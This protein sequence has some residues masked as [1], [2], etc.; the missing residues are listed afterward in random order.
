MKRIIIILLSIVVVAYINAATIHSYASESVLS[1]GNFVKIRTAESGIYKISY[2]EI[3]QMGLKPENIRILGYGGA[4]LEQ[5]FSKR[6]IDDLPSVP[7]YMYKG[8]DGKFNKGDYILFYAQGPVSWSFTGLRFHHTQNTYSQYGHYFLSD[9]AG[10]QLLLDV[11]CKDNSSVEAFDV[12]TYQNYELHELDS[13]NLIDL[14]G[15]HGGGREWYG[16]K[17]TKGS[18]LSF[19][20]KALDRV[21][22]EPATLS[23]DVVAKSFNAASEFHVN[24]LDEDYTISVNKITDGLNSAMSGSLNTRIHSESTASPIVRIGFESADASAIGYL[25]Y[26]ELVTTCSLNLRNGLLLARNRDDYGSDRPSRF[27]VSGATS[28]TQVWNITKL[29]SI[30]SVETKLN[31]TELTFLSSNRQLQEYVII[32]PSTCP[33]KR[34]VEFSS[35]KI[36]EKVANQNLHSLADVEMLI[37]TNSEFS[38][39]AQKLAEAHSRIDGLKTQVVT[40]QQVYNEFSSGTTDATSFRWILKMLRDKVE[41]VNCMCSEPKY[42]LLIG[43]GTFDN[44]KLLRTSGNNWIVTYQAKNSINE[45]K[46]YSSDDYFTFLDDNEGSSDVNATMDLSVGRL[47]VNT[48]E[49]ADKLAD[50]IIRYISSKQPGSW[51]RQLVFLADDGDGNLHTES[52]DQGAEI[53]RK[54]N[55]DFVVNKIYL[56]AYKQLTNASG[57][58]YPIAKNQLDNFM[59]NGLLLFDYCG[60]AGFNNI[61]SELMLTAKE[62]REMSNQNQGF[63]MLA[64][65]NFAQFD[66]RVQSAA[67]EAVLNPNGGAI[68]VMASCRTVYATQNTRLNNYLME[69]LFEHDE[70][71][72]YPNTIGDAIRKA[73]NKYM[74]LHKDENKLPYLLLGDPAI[75]LHYPTDYQVIAKSTNDTL[76]ALSV[77]K[78]EGYIHSSDADTLKSFNGVVHVSVYDKAAQITT[79]DNDNDKKKVT[80]IDYKNMIFSGTTEVKDGLFEFTMMVPKDIQYNYGTGRMV[81]YAQDTITESEGVGYNEEFVVGGSSNQLTTDT[82]GPDMKIYLNNEA[83]KDGDMTD[84]QPHFYAHISDEN[85]INTIG[86]GIGHDLLL[87]IDNDIKQTY[88]LNDYFVSKKGSYSEG[89]ISY[90]LSELEEGE[91][92]LMF[93]AWD[94]LNNSS[95][96]S[97]TFVV[98]KNI[99]ATVYSVTAYPNPVSE[100]GVAYIRV[101][102]DHPDAVLELKLS[103][104][105]MA[106]NRKYYHE[107]IGADDVSINIPQAGLAAGLYIYNVEIKTA[108]TSYTRKA[109]KLII[110]K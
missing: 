28:T 79:L 27:H 71:L 61:T 22:S 91:H 36:F 38:S 69:S 57:E 83:F 85:G 12:Y 87:I 51:K 90:K 33:T 95:S 64:T 62:V 3:S 7:F 99:K 20:M 78:I 5:D 37:I 109:G 52:S 6:K 76:K 21:Y 2:D 65:C 77:N 44:R 40:D 101:E 63:W 75:R 103:V 15:A 92:E 31:G 1:S 43:D 35:G 17:F 60:H 54:N 19:P 86:N 82:L 30:Y 72:Y 10:E 70:N 58:S 102:H 80:Y 89:N 18:V 97:L 67:E 84:I 14:S 98:K 47:T 73:K 59:Q 104:Y 105:D 107:Q 32:D 55:P 66:A 106:G 16:E 49:E 56:D 11:I 46:A 29:D 110:V 4:M 100:S 34:L 74:S 23:V 25:N 26:I 93:R 9:N 96:V 68:S 41:M 50:K 48:A 45:V 42:L 8:S 39:A 81:F 88:I 108:D 24:V 13:L 53:V 94:L